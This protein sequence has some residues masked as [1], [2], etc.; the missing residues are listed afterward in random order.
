MFKPISGENL[1][2]QALIQILAAVLSFLVKAVTK[3]GLNR[4][5]G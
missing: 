4:R 2:L 5:Q 3:L 1:S